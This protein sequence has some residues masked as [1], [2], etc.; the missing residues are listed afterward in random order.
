VRVV[1]DAN[2]LLAAILQPSGLTARELAR[3][4]VEFVSPEFV[5]EELRAVAE[6]LARRVGMS[7]RE[8]RVREAAVMRRVRL[9]GRA[10][11]ARH[12]RRPLAVAVREVD[13]KDVQYVA[14][15]LACRARF[16]WTRDRALLQA[17]PDMAV[18]ILAPAIS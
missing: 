3:K 6:P 1:V 15:F 12:E 17:L 5:R 18:R 13:P 7:R 14:A 8:W 10:R 16:L 11:L 2:I 4:D 9:L